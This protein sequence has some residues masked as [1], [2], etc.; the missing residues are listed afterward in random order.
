MN[1]LSNYKNNLVKYREVIK[2]IKDFIMV[3]KYLLIYIIKKVYTK[4]QYVFLFLK[5]KH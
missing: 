4:K 3:Y 2:N 5:K 1:K